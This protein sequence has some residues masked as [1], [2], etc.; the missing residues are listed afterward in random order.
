MCVIIDNDTYHRVLT[1]TPDAEYVPMHDWLFSGKG[2]LIYGGKL[3]KELCGHGDVVKILI[4]LRQTGRAILIDEKKIEAVILKLPNCCRS[5]DKH[6][7]GLAIAGGSRLLCTHDDLLKK[8]FTDSN[9]IMKPRGKIYLH[10]KQID[11]IENYG[12]IA[13]KYCK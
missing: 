7:L 2:K 3:A 13:C 9:I 4:T 1:N 8:D 5:N 6:V 12:H 11:L 10:S